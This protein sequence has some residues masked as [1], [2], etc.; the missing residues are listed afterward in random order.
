MPVDP[1]QIYVTVHLL[2]LDDDGGG[3]V[4]LEYTGGLSLKLVRYLLEAAAESLQEVS[5]G[6]DDS[7][8]E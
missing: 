4:A 8:P 1:G 5:D 2:S 6:G 7:E 3:T